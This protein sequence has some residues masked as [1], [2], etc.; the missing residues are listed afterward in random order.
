MPAPTSFKQ[1]HQLYVDPRLKNKHII[2]Y[3]L[4][5]WIS[6]IPFIILEVLYF[7]LYNNGN[8]SIKF[9]LLLILPLN[10]LINY[11]LLIVTS[12]FIMRIRLFFL[13]SRHRPREGLFKRDIKNVDYKFLSLRNFARFFPAYL[14]SSIPFPWFKKYL[15]YIAFGV[16]IGKG[17]IQQDS[18]IPV[19]F[20]EIGDNVIFGMGTVIMS[21]I[22]E[23]DYLFIK[24][25]TIGDN[26]II[27]SKCAVF[28]GVI[29]G[30]NSILSGS[31]QVLPN[32]ILEKDSVYFGNPAIF[33]NKRDE[34]DFSMSKKG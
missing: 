1:I 29:I 25:V 24:K 28:P 33:M 4:H 12:I 5:I 22:I 20:I 26:A 13:N 7:T 21:Y 23:A 19:E 9:I 34:I 11:Y 15:Y 18:W 27:G 3:L 16:R 10:L 32:Q 31:S 17:G 30:E 2:S 14:L 6:F 8:T